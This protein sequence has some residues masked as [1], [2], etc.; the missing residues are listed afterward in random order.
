MKKK[1]GCC[2]I[3]LLFCSLVTHSQVLVEGNQTAEKFDQNIYGLGFNAGPTSGVGISFRNHFPSRLSI[4]VAL[5][6]IRYKNDNDTLR[7]Y[8]SF[9]TEVQYDLVRGQTT[10][11]YAFP[12]FSYFYDEI[13]RAHV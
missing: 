9:G 6:V 11:F 5:G 1:L 8:F 13:G 10:R 7:T 4:Q 2:F 12:G 3:L